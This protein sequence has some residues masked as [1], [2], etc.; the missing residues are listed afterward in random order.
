MLIEVH[1]YA[2]LAKYLPADAR[3]KA[4]R[5]EIDGDADIS[6]IIAR[7]GVPEESVKLVFLN[8]VH[9][10]KTASLKDGDR[11]GL[12]PPVGGG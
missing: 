9:A 7:L 2:T 5:L 1:L 11:V 3:D 6:E 8:G 12:F 4:C 10:A